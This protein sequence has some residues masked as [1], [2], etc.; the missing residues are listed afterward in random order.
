M[1]TVT[2]AAFP[3]F[4]HVP[5]ADRRLPK[6]PVFCYNFHVPPTGYNT[7][8]PRGGLYCLVLKLARPAKITVGRLGCKFFPAGYYVYVGSARRGLA[9]RI[10]RHLRLRKKLHWHIDYLRRKASVI[11]VRTY[12]P[13]DECALNRRVASLPGASVVAPGF[14]SSDCRCRAHLHHFEQIPAMFSERGVPAPS[15]RKRSA[16]SV[17]RKKTNR[18]R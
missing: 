5:R 12:E 11:D 4:L 10:A 15:R 9:G 14:G 3:R 13:G 7:Q 17:N 6:T 18:R 8:K 2:G 16:K 1:A